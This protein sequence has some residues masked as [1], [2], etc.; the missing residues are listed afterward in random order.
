M[1][2]KDL[3]VVSVYTPQE[4]SYTKLGKMLSMPS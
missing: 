3:F 4:G 1:S 2:D